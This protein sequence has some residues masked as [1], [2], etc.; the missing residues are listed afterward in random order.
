MDMIQA[1]LLFA[2]IIS[3]ALSVTTLCISPS[4][5]VGATGPSGSSSTVTD[6]SFV[7]HQ[8][9]AVTL[10]TGNHPLNFTDTPVYNNAGSN[11]NTTTGNFT[12]PSSGIYEFIVNIVIGAGEPTS[13]IILTCTINS[14]ASPFYQVLNTTGL[15][16]STTFTTGP[17]RMDVGNTVIWSISTNVSIDVKCQM[18]GALIRPL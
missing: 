1:I 18:V 9:S 10:A 13:T 2:I 17:V 12:A 6:L 14:L 11:L 4:K 3:L 5:V 15:T 8:G 7:L 16:T